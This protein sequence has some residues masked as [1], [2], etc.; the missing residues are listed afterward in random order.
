LL[1]RLYR[2]R[3]EGAEHPSRPELGRELVELV[4]RRY[5]GRR[6]E[7]MA[8]AAYVS[9]TLAGLP[10]N[11]TVTARLRRDAALHGPPPPRTGRRG[12]P[13]NKDER[14]PSLAQLA[15]RGSWRT[16]T[17]SRYGKQAQ[18][19]TLALDCLWYS[20]LRDQPVRVVL[21]R[22]RKADGFDIALISTDTD[23]SACDLLAC[24]SERWAIEVSFQ[25]A[26]QVLGVG[27]AHNRTQRAVLRTVP[28]G[29]LCQS[30]TICWYALA[31]QADADVERRRLKAPWH[32][33]KRAPSTLDML[34]AL[35]REL[36]RAQYRPG[37]HCDPTPPQITEPLHPAA[38]E[39]A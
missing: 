4:A 26:K 10:A 6:V 17:V 15:T 34:A 18:V 28:F 31:G 21:C 29:F 3:R 36:I 37:R 12:R 20:V 9:R 24:Y 39:A 16:G 33:D 7:L 13:R 23:T 27:E 2:L 19:E 22:E 5:P 30:I 35:R 25:D 1:F 11:V 8:D 14:L 38:A 32:R